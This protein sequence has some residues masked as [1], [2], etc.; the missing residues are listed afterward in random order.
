M[1]GGGWI[2]LRQDAVDPEAVEQQRHCQSNRPAA[3]DENRGI[4]LHVESFGHAREHNVNRQSCFVPA[5]AR[6]GILY[7]PAITCG[8]AYCKPTGRETVA[9]LVSAAPAT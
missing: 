8:R 5:V 3:D 6:K 7:G 4:V 2:L 9:R 1:L